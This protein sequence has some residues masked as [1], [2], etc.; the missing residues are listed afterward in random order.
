[1]SSQ[2]S[3]SQTAASRESPGPGSPGRGSASPESS[4][5][6][7]SSWSSDESAARVPEMR[8]LELAVGRVV[9]EVR[10]LRRRAKEAEE[11]AERIDEL[12]REFSEGSEDP[13][14]LARKVAKLEGENE[15]LRARIRRGREGID[16]I[17]ARI[18]F[19][20][21]RR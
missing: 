7:S 18:R 21:D 9:A 5:P 10:G 1:M 17:M 3:S 16:R 12:L 8:A 4:G 13:G 2:G 11:R 19:L 20:E 15:A 6:R 14:T